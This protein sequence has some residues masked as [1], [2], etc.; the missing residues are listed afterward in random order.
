MLT[1][2]PAI[3]L[4]AAYVAQLRALFVEP[5]QPLLDAASPQPPVSD[6]L[7]A[8]AELFVQ[9][10]QSLGEL[11]RTSLG[12][13]DRAEQQLAELDL[14]T[15]TAVGFESA[16]GLLASAP[17]STGLDSALLDS[18]RNFGMTP[19][20]DSL[21]QLADQLSPG[22]PAGDPGALLDA[23]PAA[24]AA[25][26]AGDVEQIRQ[27]LIQQA[28]QAVDSITSQVVSVV[29]AGV[30]DVLLLNGPTILAGIKLLGSEAQA[31]LDESVAAL[32]GIV[33][34]LAASAVSLLAQALD[35]VL[36]LVGVNPQARAQVGTWLDQIRNQ[37]PNPSA[38][39]P[40]VTP[41]VHR[42]LATD[43]I[44]QD[45]EHAVAGTAAAVP[46]DRLGRARS[47]VE[48][49]PT[50]YEAIA[51]RVTQVLSIV[52]LVRVAPIVSTP[53]GQVVVAAVLTG[54]VGYALYSGYCHV[55]TGRISFNG[56]FGFDIP[57]R[58][59]GVRATVMATVS[60]TTGD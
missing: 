51:K 29:T 11:M 16:R 50:S 2:G 20:Q 22:V 21:D 39:M 9:T 31:L 38:A 27:Q 25:E 7:A 30:Q 26:P 55:D 52:T 36:A 49:L 18:R 35:S 48:K 42:I 24:A 58:T 59:I 47:A 1:P 54:L 37:L 32:D 57:E 43:A 40:I 8:R 33:R 56:R 12:S 4:R 23:A 10:S 6:A 14:L 5:S 17:P 28:G 60:G 13:S 3:A 53:Q 15:H 45:V 19:I 44:K 46:A 41:L 34:R